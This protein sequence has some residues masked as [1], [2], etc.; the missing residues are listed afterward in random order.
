MSKNN[1]SV[2]VIITCYNY[3]EFVEEAVQSVLSQTYENIKL[4]IIDDGS[5][6]DSLKIISKYKKQ[7]TIISRENR[8][9]V[10]TRNEA[11]K[12]AVGDFICFLDADDYFDP[13]YIEKIVRLAKK[14]GADVVFPNWHVFGDKEYYTDFKEFDL[15]LLVRQEI[16]CTS[17]SLIRRSSIGSHRFESKKVAEDWDFFLG[18]ALDGRKFKL[19]KGS[20]INYRV[21]HNTR[22]AARPYWEDMYYFCDILSKWS[23]KYPGKIN[24]FD[25]PI[26]R[27][28][29]SDK[30]VREKETVITAQERNIVDLQARI[31]AIQHSWSYRAGRAL[32][33]PLRKI[34]RLLGLKV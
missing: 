6:D 20:Y 5:T 19:A 11:I 29:E 16:H 7:A 27:G 14:S 31:T 1:P 33:K 17:E 4:I 23:T 12:I 34:N 9:I 13:D 24:A 18:M 3:A 32:T 21:R 22:G 28:S 15:Q 30:L 10:Y 25:L 26:Y 2:S 8:G